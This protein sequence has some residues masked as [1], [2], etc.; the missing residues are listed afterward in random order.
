MIIA[1]SLCQCDLEE[2]GKNYD[3]I[4]YTD[5][6]ATFELEGPAIEFAKDKKDILLVDG[7]AGRILK[8]ANVLI[9]MDNND[10]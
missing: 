4:I 5:Q 3:Q 2:E 6:I 9:K 10:D 1:I 7:A 8:N